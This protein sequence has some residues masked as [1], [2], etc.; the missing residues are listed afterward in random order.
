MADSGH[1]LQE[2]AAAGHGLAIAPGIGLG[3]IHPHAGFGI[4]FTGS[5]GTALHVYLT[6]HH[7]GSMTGEGGG[8]RGHG[9][10]LHIGAIPAQHVAICH[11]AISI[12]AANQHHTLRQSSRGTIAQGLGQ[13]G[14][15]LPA[16]FTG[17][18]HVDAVGPALG[19]TL[20]ERFFREIS[21][22][23]DDEGTVAHAGVG[24]GETF[25]IRQVCQ[26][27]PF[28]RKLFVLHCTLL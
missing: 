17:G 18:K 12:A 28:Q 16:D 9:L 23:A 11:S 22:T 15:I 8:Q 26:L 10:A 19:A 13:R 14:G 24:A 4:L 5:H 2:A 3:V 20:P 27:F 21:T 1:L 6:A 7:R 25:N